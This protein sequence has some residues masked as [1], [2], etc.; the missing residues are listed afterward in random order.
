MSSL[1]LLCRHLITCICCLYPHGLQSLLDFEIKL[2]IYLSI[3]LHDKGL[4]QLKRMEYSNRP[5]DIFSCFLVVCFVC[6]CVCAFLKVSK[7]AKIR[8]RCNQVQLSKSTFSNNYF[9]NTIWVSNKLDILS[10]LICVQTVCKGYQET[11]LVAEMGAEKYNTFLW[12]EHR[13]GIYTKGLWK[14]ITIDLRFSCKSYMRL[15]SYWQGLMCNPKSE[16]ICR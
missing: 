15:K 4:V 7:G 11:I 14:C 2:S 8:N 1:S 5:W 9:K 12:I 10:G 6:V 16:W 3:Y 13:W